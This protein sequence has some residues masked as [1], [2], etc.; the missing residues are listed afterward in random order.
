MAALDRSGRPLGYTSEEMA[1]YS[2]RKHLLRTVETLFRDARTLPRFS[3]ALA[4]SLV[5]NASRPDEVVRIA[6]GLT[7][8]VAGR[9]LP[10]PAAK[11][12]WGEEGIPPDASPEEVLR[13][14]NDRVVLLVA[15]SGTSGAPPLEEGEIASFRLLPPEAQ[16]LVVRLL[17]A[18][19][20]AR[21]WL[22]VAYSRIGGAH[23]DMMD[24]CFGHSG[25]TPLESA[26]APL[27]D[28]RMG[29]AAT[30]NTLAFEWLENLDREALA[31]A[32]VLLLARVRQALEE[33]AAA[34]KHPVPA[35]FAGLSLDVGGG[36]LRVH[37]PGDDVIDGSDGIVLDLGGND[38]WEGRHGATG[39]F[40]RGISLAIDLS[41]DDLWDG[42]P[43]AGSLA[44]GLLGVGAVLDMAGDDAY[45]CSE[46]GLGAAW[47]GTGLL[48][49]AAGDDVYET[50]TRWGQGIAF[51][52]VGALVDLAGDDRYV[53]GSEGQ[54]Y[55]TTLGCGLLLDVSGDDTYLARDDGNVSEMYL[56]RSVSMA[57]GVG[58]G[59]RADL[60]D[61]HSLAGGF[62]VL[63]DGAGNDSYRAECWAHGAGYWW[64]VGILEDLG[65]DDEYRDGKYSL[66]SAAHFAVGVCVDASGD[67]DYNV[68][69]DEAVN[70]YQGHA[71]DGSLGVFVDGAGDDR[72]QL[73]A[74]CGGSG[75]LCSMGLF[76]DRCGDDEYAI[77]A[78]RQGEGEGWPDTPPLGSA[79]LSGTTRSW[80]DDLDACGVFLD[81]G[82]KDAYTGEPGPWG[83]GLTWRSTRG[84]RSKGWGR[85]VER[86]LS[87]PRSGR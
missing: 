21:P 5:E 10:L 70:Q 43:D 58:Q 7:D 36:G 75:D 26:T 78:V 86:T 19:R 74:H 2:G 24:A 46:S 38:R 16:R 83:D 41:G 69:D 33:Y 50:A 82:G 62:G 14:L 25:P 67:D 49:D 11:E 81:T 15:S 22:Q 9:M 87:A 34:E 45:R 30:T 55:G 47:F 12:G 40:P 31:F 64:S 44:C 73:R 27:R 80:R 23:P 35:A 53:I 8:A 1:N 28:E 63:V 56:G 72:Y 37:G 42:G 39:P 57:Q 84:P 68:G 54:G 65:G 76:F 48:F 4:G 32:S 79:T 71:R 61:G 85:D 3:G 6:Y 17:L 20:D 66:G 52:G 77:T 29:Q 51:A 60:G 13:A 18:E 59:R